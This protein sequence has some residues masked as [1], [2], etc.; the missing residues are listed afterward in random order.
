MDHT[1]RRSGVGA[2]TGKEVDALRGTS[3]REQLE[4]HRGALVRGEG[5]VRAVFDDRKVVGDGLKLT[6]ALPRWIDGRGTM[7]W[8]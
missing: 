3:A 7:S 1:V 4:Y 8:S 6:I 5:A 2:P